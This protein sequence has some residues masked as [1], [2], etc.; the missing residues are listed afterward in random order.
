VRNI[1]VRQG[2]AALAG[3]DPA[4]FITGVKV[5]VAAPE[6]PDAGG[7]GF[8]EALRD[9]GV[10]FPVAPR[11][12]ALSKPDADAVFRRLFFRGE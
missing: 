11:A 10:Q 5:Q 12:A 2:L 3:D 1:Y 7:A 6:I 9:H 8:V 4:Y